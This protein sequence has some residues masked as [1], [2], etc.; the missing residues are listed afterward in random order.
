M[1]LPLIFSITYFL[2]STPAF[3]ERRMILMG[4]GGEPR[5]RSSSGFDDTLTSLDGYLQN[6]KWNQTVVS[7]NGGHS[8]TEN[9]IKT[10][11]PGAASK[12]SFTPN[13]YLA[14]IK[15]YEKQLKNNELKPGD[16]LLIM[17]DSHG[18]MASG[19]D[20]T[21][22]IAVGA[23]NEKGNMTTLRDGT[24]VSLDI[25]KNISD[26]ARE[27]GV[28]LGILDFSCHSGSSLSLANENTCVI[29]SSGPNH[30]GYTGFSPNFISNMKPG[31]SL[32]DVF[33]ESRKTI[34]DH[35]FP[36]IS[37]PEGES[38]NNDFYPKITPYLYY[39]DEK[40]DE[41]KMVDYILQSN[42]SYGICQRD[43]HFTDLLR[44][45]DSLKAVSSWN[46]NQS[47]P[48]I[49]NIKNLLAQYKQK[50]DNYFKMLRSWGT[51]KFDRRE[52]FNAI[53]M[54]GKYKAEF[55]GKYSWKELV[56]GDF[57]TIIKNVTDARNTADNPRSKADFQASIDMH[58][59]ARAKQTEILAQYPNL[60]DYKK[61]LRDQLKISNETYSLARQIAADERKLY[62]K[63]Y[64]NLKA[65]KNQKNACKD[66]VL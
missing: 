36:M 45:I 48:E 37:T 56:E 28:K 54:S 19:T 52:E 18:A 65:Q 55:S 1:K 39:F 5:S 17:I 62:D 32:E 53:V 15:N 14:I 31:R 10:K 11:F 22:Q 66:F 20:A 13:N 44:Q 3:A 21:H 63:M 2:I 9:I 34:H 27:K 6:N 59:K 25:L 4:G 57:D 12:S 47:L 23:V 7:F 51:D 26:L 64:S 16:Q 46:T 30:F 49:V 43:V 24:T 35:S 50:Q 29:S 40:T 42:T 61:K 60:R 33:L 41:D 38:I 8:Q 58:S